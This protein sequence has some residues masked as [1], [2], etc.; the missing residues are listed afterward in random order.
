MPSRKL[1]DYYKLIKHPVSLQSLLK[2]ARGVQG[3]SLPTGISDFKTWE[4]LGEEISYVWRNAQEYN[5]D[6]SEMYQLAED[7]K[8]CFAAAFSPRLQ[9]TP[10]QTHA[11]SRLEEAKAQVEVPA[12]PKIK[13]GGPKPKVTL[14]LS[15][16]SSLSPSVA[17]DTE[18][19]ARPQATPADVNGGHKS[20]NPA[21]ITNGTPNPAISAPKLERPP[22]TTNAGSPHASVKS[23]KPATQ[24]PAPVT[25]TATTTTTVN[26]TMPP[27]ALRPPS[28]SPFPTPAFSNYI[29]QP[30]AIPMPPTPRRPYSRSEALLPSVTIATHPQLKIN[31]PF[32]VKIPPHSSLTHQSTTVTLPTSH[33]FVQIAPTISQ[34]LS[35]GRSYKMFVTLN[36]TRLNQRD[37]VFHADVG[38]RTHVYEGSLASGVN[39]IEVEVAAAKQ[40][41]NGEMSTT[42]LDVEKV[43]VYANLMR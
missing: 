3:R 36:G 15:H 26:G 34:Q 14:N 42:G 18:L 38:R 25:T 19:P 7:F 20:A 40:E 4:Q 17:T 12:P 13:L 32:S 43:T 11:E 8:V 9:L 2:R 24:S 23:E 30:P 5:E 29:Q 35:M 33:Y 39:R 22:S 41:A 6:E 28:N 1:D 16:R 27:P 31:K 37:T 10:L 21:P